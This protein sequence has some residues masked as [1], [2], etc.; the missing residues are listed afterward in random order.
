[1]GFIRLKKRWLA[2]LGLLI[3]SSAVLWPRLNIKEVP[4]SIRIQYANIPDGLTIIAPPTRVIE[5]VV[6]GAKSKIKKILKTDTINYELDLS[7][8]ELGMNAFPVQ[9]E[10]IVLPKG[11]SVLRSNLSLIIV[12]VDNLIQ[13][14]LPVRV[15][16]SGKPGPGYIIADSVVEPSKVT[17]AGPETIL[18]PL[19]ETKTK[20]IEI[21][22]AKDSLKKSAMLDLPEDVHAQ[23]PENTIITHI[24]IEEKIII[25]S[26]QQVKIVGKD[27]AYHYHVTPSTLD[28]SVKGPQKLVEKLSPETGLAVFIDLK[29]IN[30]GVYV[31]YATIKVPVGVTLVSVKPEIYTV[32]ISEKEPQ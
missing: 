2:I 27:T 12:K 26:F 16:L 17:L 8:A 14:E 23:Q 19:T 13:K 4:L 31:R 21:T 18:G 9:L 3:M 24:Y 32:A 28:L 10:D 25:K 22:G 15:V 6:R 7:D 30:P 1:M 11:V 29:G 20:P 5:V